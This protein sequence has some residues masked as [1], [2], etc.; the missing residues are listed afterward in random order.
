L[1]F[2]WPRHRVTYFF[3]S[4]TK[5]TKELN[6]SDLGVNS[7]ILG[8][9]KGLDISIP[10]PIQKKSIPVALTGQ[11]LIGV[12]Q[13]G[14]GKTLAFGI[15]LLEQLAK[16]SG[17]GLILL[18]TRE[19]ATQVNDSLRQLSIAL[20]LKMSTLIGG[21]AIGNQIFSLK[22]N[23]RIVIATPGRLIDH[24][25]RKTVK[26][27]DVSILI[28]DE[29]D[30]MLDLGFAPQIEEIMGH[31]PRPRQT[32]LFS[33]TMPA[34]IVKLAAK[35]LAT[36][37]H[38]EVAPSGT[39]A[40]LVDQEIYI[41][42]REEKFQHLERILN[43][44][45]GS[46]LIFSRTKRGAA[47]LTKNLLKAGFKALEIHS[48]LSFS[49]RRYALSEFKSKHCR[50]LVA[51][52]IAARG[53]DVSGI[54]LVVNY[55]LPDNSEDYVH[56]IGRTARAGKSGKAISLAT[57]DQLKEIRSIERLIKKNLT[58]TKFVELEGPAKHSHRPPTGGKRRAPYGHHKFA[59]H[60]GA[61]R[62]RGPKSGPNKRFSSQNRRSK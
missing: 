32:M 10:T 4:D 58:M 61:N 29:A 25:K 27:N 16:S 33:A 45:Q 21:E 11:D 55:N 6:F 39:T 20:G 53:I 49:R 47:D 62:F 36:P 18:P 7:R 5:P 60:P 42:R 44:Y 51:T 46:V 41:V 52:D 31:L 38:I 56:R 26:L 40:E 17:K 2:K 24:V 13:T 34:A 15:P 3:M 48:N 23:P 14:T 28:L 57:P 43:Q 50:I 35:H 1:L 30:M 19:L 8:I 9:L 37:V 12:A 22:R 59:G 54:E